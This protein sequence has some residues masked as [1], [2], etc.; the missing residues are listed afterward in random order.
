M[1]GATGEG[2]GGGWAGS[3]RLVDTD[4]CVQS[5]QT[6]RSTEPLRD[7]VQNPGGNSNG[8]EYKAEHA[9]CGLPRWR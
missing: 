5:G 8:R 7:W 9:L 6:A 2:A 3:V 1:R 4:C